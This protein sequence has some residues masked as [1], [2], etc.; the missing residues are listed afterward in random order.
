MNLTSHIVQRILKLDPPLTRDLIV[1]RDLV[2][3]MPD[4]AELLADRW[5]P[6]HAGAPLPTALIRTPYGRRGVYGALI[7]RPLAERGYQVVIQ[8]VRGTFGSGGDFDPMWQER[9][10]GSATLRSVPTTTGKSAA[11]QTASLR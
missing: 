1:Q 3:P 11:P 2:V 10:D 7:A 6:R 5:A 9:A 8:S 4:G